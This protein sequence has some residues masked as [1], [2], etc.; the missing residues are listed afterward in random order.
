MVSS[1]VLSSP[2]VAVRRSTYVPGAVKTAPEDGACE[3]EKATVAG[4]L[5]ALQLELI[6]LPAGNPS[7][8]AAPASFTAT[9]PVGRRLT[10][11]KNASL[12]A[13]EAALVFRVA[14]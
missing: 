2:S 7:S 3:S 4:P 13:S 8:S 6:V 5:T 1:R 11:S 14:I 9:E 10:E 12:L